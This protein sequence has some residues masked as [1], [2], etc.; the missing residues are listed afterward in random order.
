MATNITEEMIE[1]IAHQAANEA[2]E[3]T[4]RIIGVDIKDMRT[5]ND[6]RQDLIH[7]HILRIGSEKA[8]WFAISVIFTTVI[9]AFL[10][11]IWEG[12]KGALRVL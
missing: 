2:V 5:I 6:L 12:L 4:F 10:Y 9:P 7:A 8:R 11:L 3:Q 1:R